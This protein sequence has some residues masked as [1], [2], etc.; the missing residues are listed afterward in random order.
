MKKI[1]NGVESII[2]ELCEGIAGAHPELS[3]IADYRIIRRKKI[4]PRKVVIIS[5]GSSGHEPSDVGFVGMGMLSAAVCGEIFTPPSTIQVYNAIMLTKTKKG[6]LLIIKNYPGDRMNFEAAAEMAREDGVLA[7]SVY[8]NDDK[9]GQGGAAGSIFVHKIAGAAAEAG[10]ELPEVKRI[11]Q[12][13]IDNTKTISLVLKPYTILS[14]SIPVL[15]LPEN[16]VE[17]GVGM[18]GEPGIKRLK[19]KTA[20]EY[21]AQ[22][23]K[24]LMNEF[25]NCT[26]DEFVFMV[27]GLGGTM[28]MELYLFS[29]CVDSILKYKRIKTHKILVGNYMTS[30]DM[31]GISLTIIKVDDELKKLLDA[32]VNVPA[33][34]ML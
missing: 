12:K 15:E 22:M 11:A 27:N 26:N 17:L 34:K 33:F 32:P 6:T 29:N 28:L 10:M 3:L 23:I 13:A 24:K 4:D 16:E 1:I 31:A 7:E 19:K 30:L 8:V 5:G 2:D 20:N 25:S 18:H 21:A 14:G 9:N